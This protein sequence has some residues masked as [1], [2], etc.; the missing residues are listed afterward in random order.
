MARLLHY[1]GGVVE[2]SDVVRA[3]AGPVV[4]DRYWASPLAA[5]EAEGAVTVELVDRVG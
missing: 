1:L 4:A 2:L 5:L 3:T